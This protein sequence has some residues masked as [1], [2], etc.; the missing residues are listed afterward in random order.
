MTHEHRPL[1]EVTS[2]YLTM[3]LQYKWLKSDEQTGK[4][5]VYKPDD[6]DSDSHP[7]CMS[8]WLI[9][10]Q[11]SLILPLYIYPSAYDRY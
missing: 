10:T 9:S 8:T 11:L 3:L 6:Y 2:V 4:Y 5:I 7:Y 1:S